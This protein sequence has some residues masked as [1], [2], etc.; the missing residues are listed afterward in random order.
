LRT[1]PTKNSFPGFL[2]GDLNIEFCL[3]SSVFNVDRGVEI[4]I[5]FE[6]TVLADKPG[7]SDISTPVDTIW[8]AEKN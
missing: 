5:A 3:D 7:L 8:N 6:F 1:G 2:D 4:G